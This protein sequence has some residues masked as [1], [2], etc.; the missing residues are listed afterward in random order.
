MGLSF[1]EVVATLVYVLGVRVPL[2]ATTLLHFFVCFFSL[3]FR[4]VRPPTTTNHHHHQSIPGKS[5]NSNMLAS[6]T[7]P[8]VRWCRYSVCASLPVLLSGLSAGALSCAKLSGTMCTIALALLVLPATRTSLWVRVLGLHYERALLFH[9]I[10]ASWA[11]M[12]MVSRTSAQT[13]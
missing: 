5:T 9:K 6:C 7:Y 10:I 1:V 12:G 4:I 8:H 13:S 2:A 11:L 3:L